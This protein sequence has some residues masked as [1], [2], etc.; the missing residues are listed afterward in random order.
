MIGWETLYLDH[1]LLLHYL[2]LRSPC[3]RRDSR[4]PQQ[5]QQHIGNTL[6]VPQP[7]SRGVSLPGNMDIGADDI[8][9]EDECFHILKCTSVKFADLTLNLEI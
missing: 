4:G 6:G 5:Q 2:I 9:R 3:G 7:R 1:A 8:Y